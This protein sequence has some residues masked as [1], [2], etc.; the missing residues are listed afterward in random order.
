MGGM[1]KLTEHRGAAYVHVDDGIVLSQGSSDGSAPICDQAMLEAAEFFEQMSLVTPDR[2]PN[3]EVERIIGYRVLRSLAALTLPTDK[4]A[5]LHQALTDITGPDVVDTGVL[6]SL[7]CL[8]VWE[9][10]LRRE[11]L[12]IPSTVFRFL[13]RYPKRRV[14]WWPRARDEI[15]CLRRLVSFMIC[16]LHLRPAPLIYAT[17]A[18]GADDDSIDC[19]RFGVVAC[20][21]SAEL[22]H[23]PLGV[24]AR[25]D[26]TVASLDGDVSKLKDPARGLRKSR[27]YSRLPPELFSESMCWYPLVAGRC[28]G[29]SSRQNCYQHRRQPG[30]GGSCYLRKDHL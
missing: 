10:I 7:L 26:W 5:W 27:P 25:L 13:E 6:H 18:M 23:R 30:L 21:P 14:C 17:D 4:L 22:L 20:M 8:W 15:A 19:G 3:P 2:R 16:E 11:F 29:N 12:S 9:A 28:S 24:A 1:L